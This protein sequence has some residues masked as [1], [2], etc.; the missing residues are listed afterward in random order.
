M[1]L[2]NKDRI[3]ERVL[4]AMP[5]EKKWVDLVGFLPHGTNGGSQGIAW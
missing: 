1:I 2:G 4:R 3:Y 5:E